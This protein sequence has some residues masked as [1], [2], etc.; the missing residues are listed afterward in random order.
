MPARALEVVEQAAAE[1]GLDTDAQHLA[2][3]LEGHVGHL[4]QLEDLA[5]AFEEFLTGDG[6]GDT[7][8]VAVEQDHVELAF[9][10][11]DLA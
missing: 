5:G 7:A 11:T 2:C 3:F 1:C 10:L 4:P 9:E 6:Q 8:L